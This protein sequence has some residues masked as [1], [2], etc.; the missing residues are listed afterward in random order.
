M[1]DPTEDLDDRL[2]R[3]IFLKSFNFRAAF[4]VPALFFAEGG[5][6]WLAFDLWFLVSTEGF[7][8]GFFAI[9]EVPTE[10]SLYLVA[11]DEDLDLVDIPGVPWLV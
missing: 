5:F 6:L 2:K 4:P 7:F 3:D 11:R 1:L 8:A 9:W 10:D